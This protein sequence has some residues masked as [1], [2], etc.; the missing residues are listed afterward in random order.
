MFT[1]SGQS[2][3]KVDQSRVTGS[4]WRCSDVKPRG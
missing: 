2:A 1:E 3:V 4:C